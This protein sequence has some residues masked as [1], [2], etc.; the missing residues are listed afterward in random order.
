M[1]VPTPLCT[2]IGFGLGV[3]GGESSTTSPRAA[4]MMSRRAAASAGRNN[5]STKRWRW[6]GRVGRATGAPINSVPGAIGHRNE[7]DQDAL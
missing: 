5:L 1:P 4:T 6:R 3:R 7:H 2:K